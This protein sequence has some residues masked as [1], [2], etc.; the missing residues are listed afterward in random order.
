M[1][2]VGRSPRERRVRIDGD[3][4]TD[5]QTLLSWRRNVRC[6]MIET[7]GA[8]VDVT[9]VPTAR[10]D[11][12]YVPAVEHAGYWLLGRGNPQLHR[13]PKGRHTRS[14]ALDPPARVA[15]RSSTDLTTGRYTASRPRM[16]ES[17]PS[18][19]G[20]SYRPI[21]SDAR[22]HGA[23]KPNRPANAALSPA[24][25]AALGSGRPVGPPRLP[26]QESAGRRR[27]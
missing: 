10:H 2:P 11:V 17:D 23:R 27:P 22:A 4:R 26:F 13:R 9:N 12:V 25:T 14:G 8:S 18:G 5:F 24:R 16:P 20:R 7:V 15:L 21:L 6:G 1:G 19:R 3:R